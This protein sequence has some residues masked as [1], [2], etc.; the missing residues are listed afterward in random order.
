MIH[1]LADV[2]SN[3]IGEGTKI[4]QFSVVLKG[5]VI[6][7]NCNI[8]SH[9]FIEDD[10]IIGHNVTLKNGV[11][12]W[13]GIRIEDNVFIGPSV[14]FTNDVYP[15]SKHRATPVATIIFKGAS[16]GANSSIRCGITI[17]KYAMIGMGAVVTK[18]V[19][20]YA[21]VVGNPAKIVGWVDELG[22]KLK[23]I[24]EDLW[25]SANGKM[26]KKIDDMMIAI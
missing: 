26:F 16:L 15:R 1:Q 25:Q 20:D 12:I 6:G 5:A 10:V 19:P 14:A 22:N 7:S 3:N 18:N 21:L 9:T 13:N 11:Y 23:M 4:W 2:Q 24:D 8:C 17:G